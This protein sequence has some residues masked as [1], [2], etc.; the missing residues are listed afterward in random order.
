MRDLSIRAAQSFW[1]GER[2]KRDNTEVVIQDWGSVGKRVHL[3]LHGNPIASTWHHRPENL[4]ISLYGWDTPVTRDRL[5][6]VLY[7]SP[8]LDAQSY[9]LSRMAGKTWLERQ[10]SSIFLDPHVIYTL[11]DGE[12][13]WSA[14]LANRSTV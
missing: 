9:F 4:S 6:A 12:F 13:Q 1:R 2:F 14:V 8:N 10:D 7:L 5:R 11:E 3:E